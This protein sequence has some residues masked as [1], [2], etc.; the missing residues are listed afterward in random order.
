MLGSL[1]LFIVI[2]YR[3]VL[4]IFLILLLLY[5]FHIINKEKLIRYIKYFVCI[6]LIVIIVLI[7]ND[8]RLKLI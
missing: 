6:V 3:A 4:P 2:L 5:G 7:I 8:I 1:I